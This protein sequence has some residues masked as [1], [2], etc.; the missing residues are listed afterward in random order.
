MKNLFKA[1]LMIAGSTILL[2]SQS[3]VGPVVSKTAPFNTPFELKLDEKVFLPKAKRELVVSLVNINDNRCPENVQCMTAGNAIAEIKLTS[4]DG[5][6][7]ITKLVL[8]QAANATDT[9]SVT[10]DDTNYSVILSEVNKLF[11]NK[12]KII[13]KKE[14]I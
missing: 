6:E 4:K 1:S 11:A 7:A 8:D 13:V 5:S 3:Y 14:A 10:L 9:I 2:T 12:A